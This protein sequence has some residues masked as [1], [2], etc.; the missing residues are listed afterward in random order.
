MQQWTKLNSNSGKAKA[1]DHWEKKEQLHWSLKNWVKF[2]CLS[3]SHVFFPQSSSTKSQQFSNLPPVFPKN[4]GTTGS[5]FYWTLQMHASMQELYVL[6]TETYHQI[7]TKEAKA[8]TVLLLRLNSL[9]AP[10]DHTQNVWNLRSYWRTKLPDSPW[11]SHFYHAPS[12]WNHVYWFAFFPMGTTLTHLWPKL[13]PTEHK[14]LCWFSRLF[15]TAGSSLCQF[16]LPAWYWQ[17]TQIPLFQISTFSR[18][19]VKTTSTRWLIS[20]TLPPITIIAA[21]IPEW[22][23]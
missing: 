16:L 15:P 8:K 22:A 1:R 20:K 12:C 14:G 17:V 7:Y 10:N 9:Q 5:C 23:Y 4:L 3:V 11:C 2:L 6:F 13:A 18:R 21:M 19:A